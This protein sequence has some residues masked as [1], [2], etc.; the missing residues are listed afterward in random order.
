MSED[1]KATPND[2]E[3]KVT[4]KNDLDRTL[5]EGREDASEELEAAAMAADEDDEFSDL[6]TKDADGSSQES[7]LYGHEA[8]ALEALLKKTQRQATIAK[9]SATV[10]VFALIGVASAPYWQTYLPASD[11]PETVQTSPDLEGLIEDLNNM[12]A[13]KFKAYQAGFDRQI[14][15]L[16]NSLTEAKEQLA[17]ANSELAETTPVAPTDT[18]QSDEA[19]LQTTMPPMVLEE[20]PEIGE[21]ATNEEI[22]SETEVNTETLPKKLSATLPDQIDLSGLKAE[23]ASLAETQKSLLETTENSKQE[24]ITALQPYLDKLQNQLTNLKDGTI[25]LKEN[26][27]DGSNQTF[28]LLQDKIDLLEG[29]IALLE[30][31]LEKATTA[32]NSLRD[33]F[34]QVQETTEAQSSMV[35]AVAQLHKAVRS[36]ASYQRELENVQTF[37]PDADLEMQQLFET[38]QASAKE[39]IPSAQTLKEQFKPLPRT[40]INVTYSNEHEGF[41]G[42]T[43][44]NMK[45]LVTIRPTGKIEGDEVE[46]IVARAEYAMEQNDLADA[47]TELKSLPDGPAKEAAA[48]WIAAVETHLAAYLLLEDLESK[49]ISM[50]SPQK[51]E[52]K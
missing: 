22:K 36:G 3:N 49:A 20:T 42:K 41:W 50:M 23:I 39:G 37:I 9:I 25:T 46:H 7:K 14:Q 35:L 21:T 45:S 34:D 27:V 13:E 24:A 8:D 28:D 18:N 33:D 16:E 15:E 38:L 52:A 19:P 43:L 51:G 5:D 26:F 11:T 2:E 4:A 31:A 30:S 44:S 47:I 12:L 1:K 29:K 17:T 6:L 48:R 10:S 40:L 32:H